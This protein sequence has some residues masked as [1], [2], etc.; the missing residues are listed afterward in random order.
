M[1][2]KVGQRWKNLKNDQN[3]RPS[4]LH[5]IFSIAFIHADGTVVVLWNETRGERA[6]GSYPIKHLQDETKW[7]FVSEGLE[8]ECPNC[9]QVKVK[10]PG[11]FMCVDCRKEQGIQARLI[12]E[13]VSDLSIVDFHAFPDSIAFLKD[14]T[15]ILKLT[16]S[17]LTEPV[18]NAIRAFVGD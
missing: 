9:G 2:I 17:D 18:I 10:S 13:Y 6:S 8:S 3:G 1:E 7:E 15:E 5:H 12:A 4:N 11:D 16:R 14:G